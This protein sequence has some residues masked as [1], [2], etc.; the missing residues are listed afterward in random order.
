MTGRLFQVIVLLPLIRIAGSAFC[1][2]TEN[3]TLLT[4][5]LAIK[6]NDSRLDV[7]TLFPE[8][9]GSI[10]D[11]WASQWTQHN[12]KSQLHV[13]ADHKLSSECGDQY[14]RCQELL[15]INNFCVQNDS[16]EFSIVFV[17]LENGILFLS[18]ATIQII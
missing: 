8:N 4:F 6:N 7:H 13:I 3:H 15:V 11:Q 18:I 16:S 12:L 2:R 1:Q 14:F 17:P 10:D 5:L 9:L